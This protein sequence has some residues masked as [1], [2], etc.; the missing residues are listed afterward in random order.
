M[1]AAGFSSTLPSPVM[2][3]PEGQA[4]DRLQRIYD[5]EG[6]NTSSSDPK[7][8]NSRVFIGNLAAE[9]VSRQAVEKMFGAYGKILGVSLH[10]SYGFVQFD[11]E[12]AAREAVKAI[13]GTTLHGLKL[14]KARA[15]ATVSGRREIER[16]YIRV[17]CL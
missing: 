5:R 6:R 4:D 10:K 13:N 17:A 2:A 12:E 11:N 7:M 14:G 15:G 8:M 9:K 16:V 1:H 3:S